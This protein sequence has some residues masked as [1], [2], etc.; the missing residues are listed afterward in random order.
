MTHHKMESI[1]TYKSLL[2]QYLDNDILRALSETCRYN[3]RLTRE[4]RKLRRAK[5]LGWLN[6]CQNGDLEDIKMLHENMSEGC[7]TDA[8]D[9]AAANGHLEVIKWL[10]ENRSEGC[11]NYAMN[12]AASYGHL[13]V[14]KWLHEN[15]LEGCTKY[16]MDLAAEY[17]HLEVVE[18]LKSIKTD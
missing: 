3:G 8:M 10:H 14:V 15:R 5:H 11:T 12:N 4:E 1:Y 16:A 17:G 2:P 13:E 9:L 7:T 18:Y 6:L